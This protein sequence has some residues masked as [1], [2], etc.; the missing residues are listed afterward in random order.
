MAKIIAVDDD[1]NVIALLVS[2]FKSKGHEVQTFN[3]GRDA[4]AFLERES[5][6]KSCNLLILDRMIG[7]ID[8]VEILRIF[9]EKYGPS[10]PVI[11]LSSLSAEKDVLEGLSKGAM[12]YVSKPFSIDVL[13][14]KA[15]QY[16]K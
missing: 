10:T 12:D 15:S 4:L 5:N 7:D 6:A 14:Q 3:K 9:R 2:T 11:I 8:G 16:L 13:I 1:P